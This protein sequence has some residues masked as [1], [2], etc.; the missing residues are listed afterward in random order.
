MSLFHVEG[1]T[2]IVGFVIRDIETGVEE[3]RLDVTGK[4]ERN[5]GRIEDGLY[6]RVDLERFTIERVEA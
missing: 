5:I 1:V 4:S 3:N 2:M 6:N